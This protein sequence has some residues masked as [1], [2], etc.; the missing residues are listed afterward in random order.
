[1]D[2]NTNYSKKWGGWID[3]IHKDVEKLLSDR[4]IYRRYLEIVKNNREI[5]SP[6]DFHIWVRENYVASVVTAIRRQLDTRKDVV[7]LMRLL[8]EIRNHN[9]ILSRDWYKNTHQ[10]DWADV[11]FTNV[12]GNGT[13][14][15]NKIADEDIKQL[16]LLGK[17]I[18][19]YSH[20]YVAHK[21]K[22]QMKKI[23][24][25][26]DVDKF[27][28]KLEEITKKY[29]LLFTASGYTGLLPTWQYDWDIIF[30]EKWIKE[31]D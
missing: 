31:S 21:S 7:S 24:T 6:A 23:P 10:Y 18:Q 30:K 3:S 9:Q 5:Q 27:I 17:S 29:I 13:F 8:I 25:F 15:D 12:A 16:E 20:K 22:D 14:F 11:D 26:D 2:K 1:M 19:E 4:E 28:E